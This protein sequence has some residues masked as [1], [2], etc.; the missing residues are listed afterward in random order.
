MRL[1]ILGA[2]RCYMIRLSPI[3]PYDIT[4]ADPE[5]LYLAYDYFARADQLPFRFTSHEFDPVKAGW[6][7]GA[8]TLVYADEE[9]VNVKYNRA[10]AG[11]KCQTR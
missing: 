9:F 2:Q 4:L 7:I 6:L 5:P 8:A 10:R 3:K 11:F 1:P